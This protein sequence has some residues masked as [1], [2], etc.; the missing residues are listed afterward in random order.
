[1]VCIYGNA[2]LIL[3]ICIEKYDHRSRMT[4]TC[5]YMQYAYMCY[6]VRHLPTTTYLPPL[7]YLPTVP[8][9]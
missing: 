3:C 8:M 2:Y 9:P 4:L 1:M 6:M 5:S 7:T